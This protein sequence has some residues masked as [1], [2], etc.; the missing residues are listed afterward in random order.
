MRIRTKVLPG[1]KIEITSVS[2]VEGE[3]VDVIIVL[4]TKSRRR[5]RKVWDVL[6]TTSPPHLFKTADDVDRYLEKERA[7]WDR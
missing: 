4:P 7:S 6:M 1:S 5:R 2:L 3:Q